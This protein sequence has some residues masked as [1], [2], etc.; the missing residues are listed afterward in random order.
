[1]GVIQGGVQLK[2]HRKMLQQALT[3]NNCIPYRA[4]QQEE[5]RKLIKKIISTPEDWREHMQTLA[6]TLILRIGYGINVRDKDDPY[7]EIADKTSDALSKGGAPGSTA[8]DVF[9]FIRH[10]PSWFKLIPSLKFAREY[11][12]WVTKLHEVPFQFV[13]QEMEAGMAKPSFTKKLLEERPE[14]EL[15]S[16]LPTDSELITDADIKGAAGSMYVA[17]QDTT[18]STLTVFVLNMILNPEIQE[19]GKEE[20]SSV[21]GHDSLPTFADR[22]KLPYV[23]YIVQETFRVDGGQLCHL[24]RGICACICCSL[25][26]CIA[27]I[28]HKSAADDTYKGYPIPAGSLVIANAYAMNRDERFYSDSTAFKPDRYIAKEKGGLGEPYPIGHF[29]FGRRVCPGIHLGSASVWMGI[30]TM[31]ATLEF[32]KAKDPEGN[33]ITP[34]PKWSTGLTR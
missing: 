23:E 7:V 28:P 1:M 16:E 9:P 13:Q 34:D 6:T 15:I 33:E 30:A 11:N 31:L 3:P 24:V 8:L 27:G 2:K 10:L 32:S 14:K 19:K 4:V 17:G 25:L 20:L 22:D 12:S 21:L 29:G 5:A 18:W 26:T